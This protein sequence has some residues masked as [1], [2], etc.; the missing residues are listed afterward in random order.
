M[1]YLFNFNDRQQQGNGHNHCAIFFYT[2]CFNI[3]NAIKY[4]AIRYKKTL[5]FDNHKSDLRKTI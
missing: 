4:L 1:L 5:N 2:L 3:L